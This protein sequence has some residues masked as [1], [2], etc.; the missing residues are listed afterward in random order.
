VV[1]ELLRRARRPVAATACAVALLGA[2]VARGDVVTFCDRDDRVGPGSLDAALAAGGVVTFSCNVP[3]TLQ[4][5]KKH[6]LARS[7]TIDGGGANRITLDGGARTLTMFDIAVPNVSLSLSGLT[8]RRAVAPPLGPLSARVEGS[9]V[10]TGLQP[11]V[12]VELRAVEIREC[13]NPVA[14]YGSDDPTRLVVRNT[15]FADNKGSAITLGGEADIA[16]SSFLGNE[17]AIWVSTRGA[18]LFG[19]AKVHDNV[20]FSS[21]SRSAIRVE[22]GGLE[23]TDATFTD[24]RGPDGGAIRING[25]ATHATLKKVRFEANTATGRGGAVAIEKFVPQATPQPHTGPVVVSITYATFS[26]N[27]AAHGGAVAADLANGTSLSISAARFDENTA[28]EEGGA[29]F[30]RPGGP[31]LVATSIVKGNTAPI[32]SGFMLIG[33]PADHGAVANTVFFGNKATASGATLVSN[34]V[35]LVNVTLAANEGGG[36]GDG[37]SSANLGDFVSGFPTTPLRNVLLADN[38]PANCVGNPQ[39]PAGG[40]NLQSPGATL[41]PGVSLVAEPLLDPYFAPLPGSPAAGTA[42]LDPCLKA[43][44]DGRDL[45]FQKRGVKGICSIGALEMAPVKEA[46]RLARRRRQQGNDQHP[47]RPLPT[48]KPGD[49]PKPNE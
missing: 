44:V 8:L 43:P 3:A 40:V 32:A 45:L 21:H 48:P 19:L 34:Q 18:G 9:V 46:G 39:I 37:T 16:Q 41:C 14:V 5:T 38:T 33:L 1:K 49:E 20:S 42:E 17:M 35:A 23:A 7:V 31:L 27:A 15:R 30:T 4:M 12:S 29:V 26:K 2:S 47:D 28:S 36:I 10:N 25:R 13:S 11:G 24:N 6:K 22:L